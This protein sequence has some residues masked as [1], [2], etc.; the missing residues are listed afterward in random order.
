MLLEHGYRTVFY[1][2]ENPIF[3]L[4]FANDYE[5]P[6]ISIVNVRDLKAPNANMY[7]GTPLSGACRALELGAFYNKPV[8]V[9]VYDCPV[10]LMQ[11][12]Y[13]QYNSR[14]EVL[15]YTELRECLRRTINSIPNLKIVTLTHNA[16]SDW[17]KWFQLDESYFDY[18]TPCVNS[19]KIDL[20]GTTDKKNWIVSVNRND[21]RKNW[22][23]VFK[24]FADYADDYILHIISNTSDKFNEYLQEFRIPPQSVRVHLNIPD[25]QKL[26]L[27]RRSKVSLYASKFEGFGI[28]AIES[29]RCG[30]PVVCYDLP[31]LEDV[32]HPCLYKTRPQKNYDALKTMFEC[33]MT[34]DVVTVP[35]LRYDFD[36]RKEEVKRLLPKDFYV[37]PLSSFDITDQRCTNS[38]NTIFNTRPAIVHF[39]SIYKAWSALQQ[40]NSYRIWQY[41]L[42][43]VLYSKPQV[44]H[45]SLGIDYTIFTFSTLPRESILESCCRTLGVPLR[46]FR[47]KVDGRWR[48]HDRIKYTIDALKKIKTEYVLHIDA[49]DALIINDLSVVLEAYTHYG[50]KMLYAAEEGCHPESDEIS[51]MQLDILKEKKT[52][53]IHLNAGVWFGKTDHIRHVFDGLLSYGKYDTPNPGDSNSDQGKHNQYYINH[54]QE[55]AIDHECIAFYCNDYHTDASHYLRV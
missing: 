6:N 18:F 42:S 16:I 8:I 2:N 14:V 35:I 39:N 54:P 49:D 7:W 32:D 30:T 10:W 31:A 12:E 40:A 21:H 45:N 46:V 43:Y 3:K 41:L 28:W 23:E 9:N 11:N 19:R 48:H 4:D 33:V 36:D 5:K 29:L 37:K 47:P 44:N 17:A 22:R 27:I 25:L 50:E 34:C 20:L 24:I 38:V 51:S 52:P 15:R 55:V 26:D 13:M 1:T 53:F